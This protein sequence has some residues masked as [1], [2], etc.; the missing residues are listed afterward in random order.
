VWCRDVNAISTTQT[1]LLTYVR[2]CFLDSVQTVDWAVALLI[3]K[4]RTL[5]YCTF[6][7]WVVH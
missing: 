5:R 7:M 3:L 6:K 4:A 2:M 1:E